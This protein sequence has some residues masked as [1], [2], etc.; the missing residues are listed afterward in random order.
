MDLNAVVAEVAKLIR[1][2][3]GDKGAAR[4]VLDP[5]LG[6]IQVDLRLIDW[7]L[8]SL[9]TR[10]LGAMAEGRALAISTANRELGP[11]AAHEMNVP[12]GPYVQVEF[13]LAGTGMQVP[14]VVREIVQR[15]HGAVV[16][17]GDGGAD[18]VAVLFP[19]VTEEPSS[20]PPSSG[21]KP[22]GPL[23]LVVD[24][25]PGARELTRRLLDDAGY[26]VLEAAGREE[27]EVI[28]HACQ[29]DLVIAPAA[30]KQSLAKDY[31]NVRTISAQDATTSVLLE[32]V[33][34]EAGEPRR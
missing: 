31:P 22:T 14:S 32:T 13:T 3:G 18:T 34:R 20:K 29:V 11:A 10:A 4:M 6:R 28:L 30:H 25:K 7:I 27:A 5:G 12:P 16:T 1:L 17:R 23:I 21:R 26:L 9:A 24:D 15:H 19:R 2:I 8:V 33:R